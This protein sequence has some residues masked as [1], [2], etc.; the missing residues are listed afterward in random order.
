MKRRARDFVS[1]FNAF[2]Y[3]DFPIT[4]DRIDIS[5]RALWT[6][7]IASTVK[8]TAEH[9]GLYTC[10]ETGGK[11]DAVIQDSKSKVW[12]KIEWE[13]TPAKFEKVNEVQKLAKA[14]SEA[15]VFYFVSYSRTDNETHASNLASIARQWKRI[16]KPL[17]VFL[18]TFSYSKKR[19]HFE[20][21]Q[22]HL[23]V[24]SKHKMLRRQEAL[25]WQ[26]PGTKWMAATKAKSDG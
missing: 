15:E 21:L 7:H 5:R 19:R 8:L 4:A 22:T 18:V 23:F 12:S 3:R 24:G 17:V 1:L 2:W 26:V 6:T 14:S 16:N 25:P 11:T 10:F 20:E 13:W 9:L